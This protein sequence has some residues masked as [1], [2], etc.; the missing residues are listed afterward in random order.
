[1]DKQN[2]M[3]KQSD[4]FDFEDRPFEEIVQ[5]YGDDKTDT[6]SIELSRD[7]DTSDRYDYEGNEFTRCKMCNREHYHNKDYSLPVCETCR[8][9]LL[10][11][12]IS[13]KVWIFIVAISIIALAML[14]RLPSSLTLGI[15]YENAITYIDENKHASALASLLTVSEVYPDSTEVLVSLYRSYYNNGYYDKAYD[16]LDHLILVEPEPSEALANEIN[17]LT[18]K[19]EFYTCSKEAFYEVLEYIKDMDIYSQ[20]NEIESYIRTNP[21]DIVA[22]YILCDLYYQL[23]MYEEIENT[24]GHIVDRYPDW[25]MGYYTLIPT[26]R[27]LKKFDEAEKYYT[28]LI[29]LNVEDSYSYIIAAK[30][31][32]RQNEDK[33]LL[34]LSQIAYELTPD[35]PYIQ[36]MLAVGYHFNNN[37]DQRDQFLEMFNSSELVDQETYEFINSLIS[38]TSDWR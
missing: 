37:Y 9:S 35:N 5:E 36:G 20:I 19:M 12:P 33:K 14:Y 28:K 1:M 31:A 6:N 23:E 38:G 24:L 27:E 4:D 17:A 29:N 11:K 18:E 10:E 7:D 16:T 3:D 2:E 13:K 8:N 34:E 26:K 32:L 21:S 25:K 30:V 15:E 22:T